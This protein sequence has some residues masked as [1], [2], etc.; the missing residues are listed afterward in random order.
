MPRGDENAA[1]ID[2]CGPQPTI[3]IDLGK[4]IALLGH[5]NRL[6]AELA[7]LARGSP[8][9]EL[10]R[11][12]RQLGAMIKSV[13]ADLDVIALNIHQPVLK[14]F[15]ALVDRCAGGRPPLLF[16]AM[17]PPDV[18]TKQKVSTA[19]YPQGILT[20]GYAAL[21]ERGKYKPV[22]AIGWFTDALK[23]RNMAACGK[24]VRGW[25]NQCN[26]PKGRPA[27]GLMEAFRDYR[28]QLSNLHSAAEAED[29]ATKCVASVHGMGLERL[30][31]RKRKTA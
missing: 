3:E 17:R 25:Y 2:P 21:V 28:P 20:I 6:K 14:L 13:Q 16:E 23:D 22:K 12:T 29:F 9:T 7:T 8:E 15:H 4:A 31:L 27:A 24:D 11:G 5:D 10:I 18:R 1:P 26:A 19:H 30:K